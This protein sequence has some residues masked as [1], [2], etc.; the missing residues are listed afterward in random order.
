MTERLQEQ[1]RKRSNMRD[2]LVQNFMKKYTAKLDMH[3]T[4]TSHVSVIIA[5]II[6]QEVEQFMEKEKHAMN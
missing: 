2:L 4:T 6:S 5:K 3:A 1:S